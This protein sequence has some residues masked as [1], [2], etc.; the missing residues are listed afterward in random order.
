LVEYIYIFIKLITEHNL[1]CSSNI[2]L[3]LSVQDC[4]AAYVLTYLTLR[5]GSQTLERH[6]VSS[7]SHLPKTVLRELNRKHLVEGFGCRAKRLVVATRITVFLVVILE[8]LLS[9]A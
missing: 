8:T 7:V 3:L 4:A 2:Q 5:N 9:V 6:C 1:T